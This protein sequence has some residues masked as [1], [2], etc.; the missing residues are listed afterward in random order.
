[1]RNHFQ[2]QGRLSKPVELRGDG[3]KQFC[4]ISIPQDKKNG[5]TE[6]IPATANGLAAQ[7]LS[8]MQVGQQFQASGYIS[9]RK[10]EQ[11]GKNFS[12]ATL[13]IT[14]IFKG[15]PPRG[16][17]GGSSEYRPTAYQEGD[18]QDDIPF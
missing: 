17:S 11:D 10:R 8:E 18:Y 5:E 12:D 15:Q 1:M 2:L 3:D 7:M 13:R 4:F 16:S 9:V 14:S 6:W